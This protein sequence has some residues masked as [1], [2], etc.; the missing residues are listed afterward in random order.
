[1]RKFVALFLCALTAASVSAVTVETNSEGWV[2]V[3]TSQEGELNQLT[4][5][6]MTLIQNADSVKLVGPYRSDPD[7]LKL[8]NCAIKGLDLRDAQ[9]NSD[10]K[11]IGSV[12]D[13]VESLYIPTDPNYTTIPASFAVNASKLSNL[14]IPANITDIGMQAFQGCYSLKG[15][16][17]PP[18]LQYIRRQAF[19]GAVL[20]AISIPGTVK[21]IETEAFIDCDKI[22]KVIFEEHL[23]ENGE[24]DVEMTIGYEAFTQGKKIMDVYIETMGEIN[25][26]NMAF[27]MSITYGQGNTQ[28]P[29]CVL[30]FPEE[31]TADYVNINHV[32]DEATASNPKAFHEWLLDH[33]DRANVDTQNGW[34]EFVNAG[35]SN[36]DDPPYP[37]GKFL[38]TFS[39]Y[40]NSRLVPKG[41]RAYI[42]TEVTKVATGSKP[43]YN[44]TL[45]R[46][47]AIPKG[48]GV[49]LYGNTNSQDKEGNPTLMLNA[50]EY[51]GEAYTRENFDLGLLPANRRNLLVPTDN[52]DDEY[53][54][55]QP[56]EKD[57]SGQV[58][59]RNFGMMR[60]S[61][62]DTG[63]KYIND[64]GSIDSDYMG[65]FR[66]KPSTIKPGLAYL[67][68]K[69]SEYDY[70]DGG[71]VI[72]VKDPYYNY[73]YNDDGTE[74]TIQTKYWPA[75]VWEDD[76]GTY[77]DAF[78]YGT[79]T[80]TVQFM[81]E[82]EEDA[83]G[84]VHIAV[85]AENVDNGYFSLQGVKVVK[86][87]KGGVY[88][89]DGKKV[90]VK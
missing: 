25:C 53:L 10:V 63:K 48:T 19:R 12:K 20:E 87:E 2:V 15:V 44:M 26:A 49:I 71:E 9:L 57:A 43:H 5:E 1:M 51:E 66:C 38:R 29:L 32:L 45:E 17:L 4:N 33:F 62:T 85:P 67:R 74:F 54:S 8:Q 68:L 82:F 37:A 23:D 69:S 72:A 16:T 28:T 84:I 30:H 34:H 39:D 61:K 36:P 76:W 40:R 60:V 70:A 13:N 59:W 18:N 41:V 14:V 27:D 75:A 78:G 11:L 21:V 80:G 24:S 52:A 90:I 55:L 7:F 73:E 35:P 79:G 31:K 77:V 89:K 65:F 58:A 6:Q 50:V 86:P 47:F 81:G 46:I 42:V 64:T 22:T 56:Y 83:D 88:I 3:T